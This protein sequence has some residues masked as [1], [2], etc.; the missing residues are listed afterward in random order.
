MSRK[1][2]AKKVDRFQ[3]SV[4]LEKAR[5]LQADVDAMVAAGGSFSTNG[6]G[7]LSIHAA[8]AYADALC[9]RAVAEKSTSTQHAD[10]VALLERTIPIRTAA[11]QS[12]IKSVHVL[13]LR[14]DEVSYTT[15]LLKHEDAK[16]M[17]A[18]LR[19]FA[20]WAEGRYAEL[21]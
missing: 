21:P 16:Q 19:V 17:A 2:R 3:A 8:I 13:L 12:A 6:V 9:I 4:Y 1:T 10:A 18:R 5:R 20:G 11:D 15:S 14:K 7:I